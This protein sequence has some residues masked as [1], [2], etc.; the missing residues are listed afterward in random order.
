MFPSHKLR[1]VAVVTA[2]AAAGL[3][4]TAGPASAAAASPSEVCGSGYRVIDSEDLGPAVIYLTYNSG[5]GY[6]CV[7]TILDKALSGSMWMGASIQK[8]G[9]SQIDDFGGYTKFAGP[10]YVSA[11]NTCIKWGGGYQD[12]VWKSGWEHCG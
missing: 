1:S 12:Y 2:V 10:V 8:S 6:N 11:P 9:G 5:N 4:A 7:T 3:L